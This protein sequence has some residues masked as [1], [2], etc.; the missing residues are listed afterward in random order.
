[1]RKK[2]TAPVVHLLCQRKLVIFLNYTKQI[3]LT[4]LYGL[5][6]FKVKLVLVPITHSGLNRQRF[7]IF[8]AAKEI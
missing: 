1:V 3:E 2:L 5:P 8:F 6:H 7:T 4:E